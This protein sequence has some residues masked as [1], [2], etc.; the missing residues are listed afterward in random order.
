MSSPFVLTPS[1]A[2]DLDEVFEY[3][4]EESG[5]DRALHVHGQLYVGFLRVSAQP[6]IG[7]LRDDLADESLRVRAVFSYLI[8]YRPETKPVQIVRV[9]HGARDLA[10]VFEEDG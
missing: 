8:I 10:K 3:V 6:G 7:H 1:A 2:R 4:L 9:I 5:I